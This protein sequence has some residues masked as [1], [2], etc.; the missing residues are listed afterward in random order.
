MDLNNYKPEEIKQL[1]SMLQ[2]MLPTEEK[3]TA[4]EEE[5]VSPIKTKTF[6]KN[7]ANN[8]KNKFLD[9]PEK[10]MHKADC[11]ID[12]KLASAPPTPRTRKFVPMNVKCRICG[13][14][15]S[16]NPAILHDSPDRYKCNN[17]SSSPGG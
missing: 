3:E 2:S 11:L 17:C 4:T 13:K 12:K 1:I 14:T 5:H 15:D 10:N 16:I 8:Q 9:M 6:S 7:K